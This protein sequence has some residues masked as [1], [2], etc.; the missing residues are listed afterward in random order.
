MATVLK[1]RSILTSPITLMRLAIYCKNGAELIK[2]DESQKTIIVSRKFA[3]PE[4]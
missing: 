3:P 2:I 1:F 4:L